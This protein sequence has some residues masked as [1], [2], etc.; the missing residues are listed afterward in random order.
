MKEQVK[1]S[2]IIA[3]AV[4]V[5]AVIAAGIWLLMKPAADANTPVVPRPFGG[6]G[7]NKTM[8]GKPAK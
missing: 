6:F 1:P 3:V 2:V 5:V 4:V 7:P 8:P